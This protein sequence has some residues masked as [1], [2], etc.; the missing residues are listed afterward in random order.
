MAAAFTAN[1]VLEM[2]KTIE[3]NAGAFYRKAMQAQKDKACR[4]FLGGLVKMEAEHERIFAEMQKGLTDA[5]KQKVT[6][7]PQDEEGLY[8]ASMADLHG[9]EGTPAVADTLTGRETMEQI[10]R[11]AID[12]ERRT[13]LFFVGLQP[14]V[15]PGLGHDRVDH[16]LAEERAHVALL[17]KQLLALRKQK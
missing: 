16:V 14:M 6:L 15:P 11:L 9:G 12:L 3:R 10:L 8:L 4:D 13:I 17:S 2:A 7:D 1:D 5:E